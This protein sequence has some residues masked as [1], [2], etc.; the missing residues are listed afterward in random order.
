M[1][2]DLNRPSRNEYVALPEDI[3]LYFKY[4]DMLPF[5]RK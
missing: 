1:W 2:K 3:P 4:F 5:V